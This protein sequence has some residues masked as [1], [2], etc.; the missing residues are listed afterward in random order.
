MR[1]VLSSLMC[2]LPVSFAVCCIMCSLGCED[3]GGTSSVGRDKEREW[4]VLGEVVVVLAVPIDGRSGEN[5]QA[6]VKGADLIVD[7]MNK[8]GGIRGRRIRLVHDFV[9]DGEP[10]GEDEAL[11]RLVERNSEAVA[12]ICIWSESGDSSSS[13][14]DSVERGQGGAV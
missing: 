8:N 9:E 1:V 5:G 11:R 10:L 6:A 13:R 4:R 3:L 14:E 2:L 12:F 7:M